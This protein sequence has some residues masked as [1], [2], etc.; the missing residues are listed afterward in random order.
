MGARG[1]FC[2]RWCARGLGVAVPTRGGG[3]GAHA[4]AGAA[5]ENPVG[6]QAKRHHGGMRGAAVDVVVPG[7]TDVGRGK[8]KRSLGAQGSMTAGEKPQQQRDKQRLHGRAQ[9]CARSF[10]VGPKGDV[11]MTRPERGGGS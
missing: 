4:A 5:H 7:R 3:M 6:H 1:N 8:V 10:A 11:R 9:R 2:S